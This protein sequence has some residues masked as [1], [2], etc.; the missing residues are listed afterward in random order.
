MNASPKDEQLAW[1]AAKW[2]V[3]VRAW[4][5]AVPFFAHAV[6]K[7]GDARCQ[8]PDLIGA[9]G[10]GLALSPSDRADVP[11]IEESQ[12]LAFMTCWPATRQEVHRRL[13][14]STNLYYG[15]VCKMLAQKETL[16]LGQQMKCER[17]ADS[18]RSNVHIPPT[19]LDGSAWQIEAVPDEASARAGAT[20][21]KTCG[22]ESGESGIRWFQ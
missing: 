18:E 20:P 4:L 16:S 14:N 9:V 15:N 22:R 21:L 6:Q 3:S 17:A 8:D 11:I 13:E 10:A 12:R 5:A 7:E 2:S 19:P 1:R